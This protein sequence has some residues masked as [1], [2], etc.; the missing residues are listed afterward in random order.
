M[1]VVLKRF[2]GSDF[3]RHGFLVFAANLSVN[4][5]GYAFHFAISRKLGVEQYGVLAALNAAYMIGTVVAIIAGTVVVKYAAEFRATNNRAQLAALVRGLCTFASLAA[6]AVIVLG[7]LCAPAVARF[8]KV[9]NVPA[10]TLCVAMIGISSAAATI[11][12]VFTGLED[13]VQMSL[14]AVMESSLKAILGIGFVYAGYGVIGAFAGWAT[15]SAASLAYTAIV[16]LL[17]YRGV[18]AGGLFI[19][20]RRLALTMA[21]VSAATVLLTSI[22]YVDVIVVKH[23][24]DATTAGLYGALSLSGKI[25]LF[26]V[27]FVPTVLLPKASRRAL[28]GE[29]PVGILTVAMGVVLGFSGIGLVV[30]YAFPAFVITTLAGASFAAGAPYVFSYGIAM[31]LLAA[32]NTIVIFKIGIHRFDFLVPLAVCAI[33][34]LVGISFFHSSLSAIIDVLI[35]GNAIAIAVSSYRIT[36]PLAPPASAQRPEAA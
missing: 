4:A 29:S 16:L 28:A 15:G 8:L 12:A 3:A 24:A 18:P 7:Y 26:F 20:V 25:L 22:S 36:A 11:R 33:G 19:D 23:Y 21:G 14:S 34:E 13:F 5:L 9:D 35:V 10:V 27:A 32:L 30:Y 6:V 2:A 31:T 17:R 1:S